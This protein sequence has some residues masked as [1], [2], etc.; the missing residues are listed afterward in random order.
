M[1]SR[2][3][4]SASTLVFVDRLVTLVTLSAAQ[5]PAGTQEVRLIDHLA[6]W[7]LQPFWIFN[8]NDGAMSKTCSNQYRDTI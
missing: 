6:S 3:V 1:C 4:D 5:A 8:E 7:M 2:C